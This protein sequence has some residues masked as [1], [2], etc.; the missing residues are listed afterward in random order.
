M[1]L[2]AQIEGLLFWKGEPV[3]IG[4]LSKTFN[5]MPDGIADAL[6]ELERDFHD[7]GIMLVR[8]DDEV[9]L[10]TAKDLS[11]II[12]NMRKEDLNKELSRASVETLAIVLYK[13]GATRSEIDYLRGVNSSF[14]LRNLAIRGI[15]EKMTHPTDTRK[16]IYKPTFDT[17]TYLGIS[18][19]EDLPEYG[20]YAGM[21]DKEIIVPVEKAVGSAE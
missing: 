10:G 12:E 15:V 14:I 3:S 19:I 11:G 6:E 16:I 7:R 21:L 8:K 2:S 9:T 13:T 18:K 4:F 17:M 20:S 1:K 5:V